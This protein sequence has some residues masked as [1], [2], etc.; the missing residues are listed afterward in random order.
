MSSKL[1]YSIAQQ[2]ISK[3]AKQARNKHTIPSYSGSSS[4]LLIMDAETASQRAL[5]DT[6]FKQLY[7]EGKSI[8]Q[9]IYYSKPKDMPV[10]ST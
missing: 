9:A 8:Y 4:F 10:K 7:A 1:R 2:L 6:F 3:V 5:L